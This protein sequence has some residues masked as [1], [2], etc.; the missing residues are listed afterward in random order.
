M[1]NSRLAVPVAALV[2]RVQSRWAGANTTFSARWRC[3]S[4][5]VDHPG[6]GGRGRTAR[7]P[8]SWGPWDDAELVDTYTYL[9]PPETHEHFVLD[10]G[11]TQSAYRD[12]LEHAVRSLSVNSR[13]G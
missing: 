13:N 4:G 1:T 12:W 10:S 2:L 9:V 3:R 11:W 8:G 5:L 6:A 7:C